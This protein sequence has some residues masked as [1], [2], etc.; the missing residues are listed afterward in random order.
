VLNYVEH[1][2]RYVSD[3][4]DWEFQ[5]NYGFAVR[6]KESKESETKESRLEKNRK[7]LVPTRYVKTYHEGIRCNNNGDMLTQPIWYFIKKMPRLGK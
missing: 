6:D 1:I 7:L 3:Q 4:F 5:G 2:V